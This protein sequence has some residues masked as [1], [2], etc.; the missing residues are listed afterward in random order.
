MVRISPRLPLAICLLVAVLPIATDAVAQRG[1]SHTSTQT[2]ERPLARDLSPEMARMR[3]SSCALTERHTASTGPQAPQ[4]G[5]EETWP[6]KYYGCWDEVKEIYPGAAAPYE[7][8]V[9]MFRQANDIIKQISPLTRRPLWDT[10]GAEIRAATKQAGDLVRQGDRCLA[11][12]DNTGNATTRRPMLQGGVSKEARGGSGANPPKTGG[13]TD[14]AP[15]PDVPDTIPYTPGSDN[16]ST[17]DGPAKPPPLIRIPG[18][19]DSCQNPVPPPGC[20]NAPPPT[21]GNPN[22]PR[23]NAGTSHTD[24]LPQPDPRTKQQLE[25]E[26]YDAVH[27]LAACGQQCDIMLTTMGK[28]TAAR[29]VQMTQ[30][31]EGIAVRTARALPD[32]VNQA[33]SATVT[34]LANDNGANHR[35]LL[36]Q[37]QNAIAAANRQLQQAQ[38]NPA[39]TLGTVADSALWGQATSGA[40]GMCEASAVRLKALGDK[41]N[42]ARK[43]AQVAKQLEDRAKGFGRGS[44]GPRCSARGNGN[45]NGTWT[46]QGGGETPREAPVPGTGPSRAGGPLA[47]NPLGG[48][49]NCVPVSIAGAKMEATGKPYSAVDISLSS[50][51]PSYGDVFQMLRENFGDKSFPE[52]PTW[53]QKL[54]AAG[55][56]RP[57]T[58]AGIEEE[59]RAAAQRGVKKPQGIVFTD[60]ADNL[61]AGHAFNA[62]WEDGRVVYKDYQSGLL[63][64]HGMWADGNFSGAT[65]IAFYRVD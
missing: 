8:C 48:N 13:V 33:I 50:E 29:L 26:A 1:S 41:I 15:L 20:P 11:E 46:G 38:R 10:H 59:L 43:A 47:A 55:V 21:N 7:K 65:D 24:C 18:G 32:V 64:Q 30:P 60:G 27:T 5:L 53:L 36:Q 16:R 23:L 62:I 17:G 37:A 35:M 19:Y 6:R 44:P 58:R 2:A 42:E 45:G 63:G 4:I 57:M 14:D 12:V 52:L 28:L 22:S 40:V 3:A 56:P 61:P 54:Q 9:Q 25:R 31:T 39:A 34:Y 49:E 51:K